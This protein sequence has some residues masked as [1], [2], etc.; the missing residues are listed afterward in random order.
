MVR[1]N[2]GLCATLNEGLAKT[3]G[4]FFAYLGSDDLW[5]PE[6]LAARVA[7]LAT[8]PSAALVY[9]HAFLIDSQN[10]I[11]DCTR[12]W[13]NYVDG[14]AREMLLRETIAPMSPTVVY[15]RSILERHSWTEDAQ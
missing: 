2:R 15:R 1:P 10:H 13:A 14:N 6:F 5:L 8:R 4:E 9:G 12:D 11:I 3:S 7:M